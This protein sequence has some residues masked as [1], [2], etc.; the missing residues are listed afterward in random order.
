MQV[1]VHAAAS[2]N[3]PP[4]LLALPTEYDGLQLVP[5]SQLLSNAGQVEPQA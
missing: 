4:G 5:A 1:S 3:L 2:L